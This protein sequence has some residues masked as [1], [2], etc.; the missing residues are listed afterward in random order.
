MDVDTG[1]SQPSTSQARPTLS[2]GQANPSTST[3]RPSNGL[4]RHSGRMGPPPADN[5]PQPPIPSMF[6]PDSTTELPS[7]VVSGFSYSCGKILA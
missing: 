7:H 3:H 5:C 2:S 1:G 4:P 6:R